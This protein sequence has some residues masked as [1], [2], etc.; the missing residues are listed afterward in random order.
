MCQ[1]RVSPAELRAVLD[2]WEVPTVLPVPGVVGNRAWLPHTADTA[3]LCGEGAELGTP[4][5]ASG[6]G[7]V[8]FR[9]G[10]KRRKGIA[11]LCINIR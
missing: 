6:E 5:C 11:F 8:S 7:N 1:H 4:I 10:E 2:V 9:S 3:A